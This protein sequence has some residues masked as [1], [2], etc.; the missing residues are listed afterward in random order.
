MPNIDLEVLKAATSQ[1]ALN[2]VPADFYGADEISEVGMLNIPIV[3]NAAPAMI[4]EV[5]RLRGENASQEIALGQQAVR[6]ANLYADLATAK[7]IGAAEELER[8]GTWARSVALVDD[9][10]PGDWRD[11]LARVTTRRAAELRKEAE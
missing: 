7:R 9:A 6:I 8:L 5:E 4:A 11:T 3:L 2:W 10:E 1:L